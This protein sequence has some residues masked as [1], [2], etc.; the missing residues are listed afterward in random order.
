MRPAGATA[1]PDTAVYVNRFEIKSESSDRIYIVAQS[2]TGRWWSCSCHG[3]IRH[4]KCK[5]LT[6]L[7]LPG[8]HQPFEPPKPRRED[9]MAKKTFAEID[10]ARKRY[11]PSKDGHGD[12]AEWVAKFGERMGFEEATTVLRATSETPRR[13]LGLDGMVTWAEVRAAY[14]VHMHRIPESDVEGRRRINAAYAILARE[15]GQ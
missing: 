8:H 13:V 1:L 14:R 4:K 3:W 6:A 11:D 5:H 2:A 9:A 10:A 15:L 12:P 7:G